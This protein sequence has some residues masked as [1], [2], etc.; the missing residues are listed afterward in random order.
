M[1]TGLGNKNQQRLR[2]PRSA[3]VSRQYRYQLQSLCLDADYV[4]DIHSSSNQAI[5]YTFGFR[6]KS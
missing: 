4:I 6:E 5:D 3:T 1:Q 2:S